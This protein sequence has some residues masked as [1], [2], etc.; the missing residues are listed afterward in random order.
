MEDCFYYKLC[1]QTIKERCYKMVTGGNMPPNSSVLVRNLPCCRETYSGRQITV[2]I[3]V[4]NL[5]GCDC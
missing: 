5:C 2:S 4:G 3:K 1:V